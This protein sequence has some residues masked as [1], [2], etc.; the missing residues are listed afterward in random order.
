SGHCGRGPNGRRRVGTRAP[1]DAR[2]NRPVLRV[3]ADKRLPQATEGGRPGRLQD[4]AGQTSQLLPRGRVFLR[5]GGR[6]MHLR[7]P[8]PCQEQQC[9]RKDG[10]G[11]RRQGDDPPG[12]VGWERG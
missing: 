8:R 12:R 9:R 1:S 11:G 7:R 5:D 4:G 3:D 6:G 2:A 10:D